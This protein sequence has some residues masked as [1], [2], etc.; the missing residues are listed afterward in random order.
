MNHTIDSAIVLRV[1]SERARQRAKWGRQD[2]PVSS[3]RV[4]ALLVE[5]AAV[6]VQAVEASMLVRLRSGLIGDVP[7]TEISGAAP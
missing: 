5:L 6:A 7:P 4:A 1:L 3:P 2:L